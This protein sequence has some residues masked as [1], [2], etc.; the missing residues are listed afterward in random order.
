[1]PIKPENKGFYALDWP[2]L[3]HAIRFR[4][5]KGRCERCGRP[6]G[7]LV[8]Q[9]EDGCWFDAEIGRWRDGH[10]RLVRRKLP[11]PHEA[12]PDREPRSTRVRVSC[13]HLDQDIGNDEPD[14]LAA[15]C[16][17]CQLNHNRPWNRRKIWL[18]AFMKKALGDLFDGP[19]A[20]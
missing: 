16:Q 2:Q 7:Q 19:Y 11:A 13:A 6:H 12:E 18:A 1:M 17:R 5:A 8:Y 3:S 20:T 10:G 15:L 9:L 4:R 14:N